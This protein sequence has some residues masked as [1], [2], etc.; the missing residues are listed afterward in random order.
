MPSRLLIR[1]SL[2][3]GDTVAQATASMHVNGFGAD[4]RLTRVVNSGIAID[5]L[6]GSRLQGLARRR[7][8][9]AWPGQSKSSFDCDPRF[10]VF[11]FFTPEAA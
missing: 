9:A 10:S 6:N 7:V 1:H 11:P 5:V 2:V 4:L 8:V 3:T